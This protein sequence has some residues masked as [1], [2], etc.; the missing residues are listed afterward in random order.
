MTAPRF[1]AVFVA[2][3][4]VAHAADTVGT[5][6][7]LRV[8]REVGSVREMS[9]E[10]GQNRL[11]I[12]SEPIAR[13]AVADPNVADL[14]VVTPMQV[15]LTAK[16]AGTTD[17]TLWNRDNQPL[18][19]AL[20]VIRNEEALKRQLK[21]LFPGEKVTV[22]AAGELVVLSGEVN[23]VRT[24][25]RVAEVARLHSREVANLISVAGNHQVQLAVRF[26]EVSRSGL[27]QIG[28]NLFGQS[29][30]GRQVGGMVGPKTPLGSF[31]P[32]GTI[33]GTGGI[34]QP[35]P[36]PT[37][38]FAQSFSLFFGSNSPFPFDVTLNLLEE[39]GLAKVLAEP[40]L[41]TLTGQE[42]RFLAG[43]EIPVPI[44]SSLGAINVLWKRFGIQLT[45]TPT[46]LD[47]GTINLRVATEVSDLDPTNG[48]VASGISIP[49]LTSRQAEATV[50]LGDG[51]SFAIAGLMSDKVRSSIDQ[52]PG[53]G[54][55]PILGALFRSSQYQRQETELL[56]VITARLVKPVAPHE[57]QP[58]PTDYLG[59][60]PG[61][62]SFFLLGA[63]EAGSP[64]RDASA[65]P[66][67]AA[68]AGGFTP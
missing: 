50:R 14:K 23:D 57:V 4:T 54:S 15:L 55:I 9:L 6:T 38:P 52:V 46:V 40:T 22:S 42:A 35:T 47:Q 53:L 68:G 20:Q 26:A 27:K 43:G 16:G 59:V 5:I 41:V 17:L 62:F 58:L 32:S 30:D 28:V 45:F 64:G 1:I 61:A 18:V 29:K 24:P 44:S 3:S 63:D 12:V 66:R 34:G 2:L 49:G 31:L 51:Q 7:T 60:E 13:I 39:T 67:G 37:Q 19:I 21:E 48:I 10:A 56:V 8:D 11:L 36:F 25:Q 65:P 33:P